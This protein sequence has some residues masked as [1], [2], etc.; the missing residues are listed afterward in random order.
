VAVRIS[1]PALQTTRLGS[2]CVAN[3]HILT[4]SLQLR[5]SRLA[6]DHPLSGHSLTEHRE[7]A[8]A[9]LSGDPQHAED[10]V[11]NHTRNGKQRLIALPDNVFA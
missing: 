3:V 9:I 10:V 5:R 4:F 1:A 7:V 2:S 11:R 8:D 6:S